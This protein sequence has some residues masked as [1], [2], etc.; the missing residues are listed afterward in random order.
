MYS[1]LAV[2]FLPEMLFAFVAAKV[3]V[4]DLRWGYWR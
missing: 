3:V 2:S 1:S 4:P